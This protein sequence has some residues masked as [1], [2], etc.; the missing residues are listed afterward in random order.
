MLDALKQANEH[1]DDV[2]AHFEVQEKAKDKLMREMEQLEKV[3][4]ATL[5][6]ATARAE[7]AEE[8]K[9]RA[10]QVHYISFFLESADDKQKSFLLP[11]LN[12]S[13]PEKL[14]DHLI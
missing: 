9:D 11:T 14:R 6:E 8:K 3:W 13:P 12:P 4:K 1:L 7:E 10:L 5:E 2:K